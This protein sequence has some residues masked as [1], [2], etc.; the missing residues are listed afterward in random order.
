[1]ETTSNP[2]FSRGSPHGSKA[3]LYIGPSGFQCFSPFGTFCESTTAAIRKYYCASFP[4]EG[5]SA[6]DTPTVQHL[7]GFQGRDAPSIPSLW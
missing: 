1:M 2:A 7:G 3:D 6:E 5:I 4:G